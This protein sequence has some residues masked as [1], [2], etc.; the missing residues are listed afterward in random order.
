MSFLEIT[1]LVKN[2]Y[3]FVCVCRVMQTVGV[4]VFPFLVLYGQMPFN[5]SLSTWTT[6]SFLKHVLILYFMCWYL[7][8]GCRPRF[9]KVITLYITNL[10]RKKVHIHNETQ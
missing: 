7:S 3:A 10:S 8:N 4:L 5:W 1:F 6:V 9:C 2:R